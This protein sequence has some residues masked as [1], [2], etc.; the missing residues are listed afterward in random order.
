MKGFVMLKI[1]YRNV[2]FVLIFSSYFN[3]IPCVVFNASLFLLCILHYHIWSSDRLFPNNKM[4]V[5]RNNWSIRRTVR[6]I[7]FVSRS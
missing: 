6:L 4:I 5:S 2:V 3:S 7:Y 1:F